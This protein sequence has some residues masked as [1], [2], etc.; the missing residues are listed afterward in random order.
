MNS[1]LSKSEKKR[2]AKDLEQLMIELA[3]LTQVEIDVLPC[4]QEIRIE[5]A[6]ARDLKGGTSERKA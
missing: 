2:R 1:Q 5:I 6:A 3:A 4:D